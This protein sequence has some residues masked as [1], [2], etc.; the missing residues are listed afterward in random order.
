MA[1]NVAFVVGIDGVQ[2][3]IY[4]DTPSTWSNYTPQERWWWQIV[5]KININTNMNDSVHHKIISLID[6]LNRTPDYAGLTP[7]QFV[8]QIIKGM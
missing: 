7:Q 5:S 1:N 6:L 3:R 4:R 8:A 2:Y